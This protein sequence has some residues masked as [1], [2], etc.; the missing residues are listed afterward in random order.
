MRDRGSSGYRRVTA[1]GNRTFRVGYHSQRIRRV[2]ELN[3]WLLPTRVR[4]ANGR[5]HRGTIR[6]DGSNERWCS[7]SFAVACTSGEAGEV[8]EVGEVGAVGA[9]GAVG[10]ALD[11]C[12]RAWLA[13]VAEPRALAGAD[14]RRLRHAAVAARGRRR[15]HSRRGWRRRSSRP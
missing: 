9:V 15:A 11:C 14:L 8:G 6:G 12:D 13:T 10:F 7:D 5:A 3:G 2:M 4:R 1:L